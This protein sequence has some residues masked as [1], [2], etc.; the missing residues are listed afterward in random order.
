MYEDF[1]SAGADIVAIGMGRPDMAADF[2]K[3][4]E[5][6]FRLLVDADQ[7]SY[8]ALDFK[9]GSLLDVA[10]PK[11]WG[12]GLKSMLRGT[13]AAPTTLDYRQLG[14]AAIVEPG[15]RLKFIHR[16]QSSDDNLPVEQLLDALK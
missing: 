15:G 9:R 11:V 1:R 13:T 6:P 3:R 2:K 4:F 8:R 5:I 7:Q 10:G 16:S 12:S 14:G